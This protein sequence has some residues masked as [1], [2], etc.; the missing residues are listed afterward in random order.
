MI[1]AMV[2]AVWARMVRNFADFGSF[3]EKARPDTQG[4]A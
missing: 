1:V 4:R 3:Q 2:N